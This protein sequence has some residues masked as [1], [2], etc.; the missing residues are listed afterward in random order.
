MEV[1][2]KFSAAHFAHAQTKA[3]K[4]PAHLKNRQGKNATVTNNTFFGP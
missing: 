2:F 1:M 4:A 3:R